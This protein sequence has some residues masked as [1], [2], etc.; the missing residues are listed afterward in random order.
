MAPFSRGNREAIDRLGAALRMVYESQKLGYDTL[1]GDERDAYEGAMS[2]LACLFA[3]PLVPRDTFA[4]GAWVQQLASAAR[5]ATTNGP[6]QVNTSAR[7]VVVVLDL[8]AFVTAASAQLTVERKNADGSYTAIASAPALTAV[9][10]SVVL[11]DPF[12]GTE[13]AGVGDSVSGVLPRDWRVRVVHG[14]ANSHTYSV[15]AY[16]IR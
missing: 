5:S 1:T 16:P 13:P 6:D 4:T 9:N 3:G 10:R 12:A 14:N 2:Q 15:T 7:G 11:V 8:T